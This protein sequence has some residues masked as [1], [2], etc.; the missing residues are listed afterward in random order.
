MTG[1]ATR[2]PITKQGT[3][4]SNWAK[5]MHDFE[6]C[7]PLGGRIFMGSFRRLPLKRGETSPSGL[8][9][10]IA[11]DSCCTTQKLKAFLPKRCDRP[12][13]SLG[14]GQSQIDV[15]NTWK[16]FKHDS[17]FPPKVFFFSFV[18]LFCPLLSINRGLFTFFQR[19]GFPMRNTGV[20]LLVVMIRSLLPTWRPVRF[21]KQ[22][23]VPKECRSGNAPGELPLAYAE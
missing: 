9:P 11:A 16:R 8:W 6:R 12:L 14:C 18:L 5:G 19:P 21:T 2:F 10:Q 23:F 4:S 3:A 13:A 17:S 20:S 1:L 22:A 15:Q 7:R